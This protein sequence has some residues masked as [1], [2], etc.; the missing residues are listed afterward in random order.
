MEDK[1]IIRSPNFTES[2]VLLRSG[3]DV[4]DGPKSS[5]SNDYEK[6]ERSDEEVVDHEDIQKKY[7]ELDVKVKLLAKDRDK[8][9]K[10][11]E[12]L[13]TDQELLDREKSSFRDEV[14][15]EVRALVEKR[16]EEEY[17]E[18]TEQLLTLID[19]LAVCKSQ[20]I[21][22]FEEDLIALVYQAVC[23]IIGQSVIDRDMIVSTV[24]EVIS[25][26]QDRMQ[27][28]LLVSPRDYSLIVEAK[29]ELSRGLNN[30]LE[31]ISDDQ[32]RYGGCVLKTDAGTI[33]ARLEQQ[34]RR[35]LDVLLEER[36]RSHG[37]EK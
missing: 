36:N 29:E 2:R 19:S 24:R 3:N 10:Q 28:T 20:E 14:E 34:L 7:I 17:R 5:P 22:D 25:H 11:F 21:I 18:K 4:Y 12:R 16:V 1:Y 33:D 26:A 27:M 9:E 6:I 32:V 23:K 37:S 31:V 8:L 30:R 35:L 13:K 15:K